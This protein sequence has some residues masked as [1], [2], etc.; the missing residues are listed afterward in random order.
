MG[1]RLRKTESICQSGNEIL[2]RLDELGK[3]GILICRKLI[4]YN[5]IAGWL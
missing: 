3:Q 2:Q 1:F 5:P 4:G